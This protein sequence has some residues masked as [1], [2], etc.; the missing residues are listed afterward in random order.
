MGKQQFT[1][2]LQ[3]SIRVLGD[4]CARKNSCIPF[5]E[6]NNNNKLADDRN[7]GEDLKLQ[8]YALLVGI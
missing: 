5:M 1:S 8:N 2:S 6:K 4:F 3:K 7:L